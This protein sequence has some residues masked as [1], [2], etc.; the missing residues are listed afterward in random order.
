M[1]STKEQSSLLS[2]VVCFTLNYKT[3]Q[4]QLV[5]CKVASKTA[6]IMFQIALAQQINH[7]TSIYPRLFSNKN[8]IISL[9]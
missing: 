4:K 6:N 3:E 8:I 9:K 5:I 7:Q 1:Q 2:K